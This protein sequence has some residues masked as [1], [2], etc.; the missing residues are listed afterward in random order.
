MTDSIAS[1][2]TAGVDVGDRYSVVCVLDASGD[3]VE[4]TRLATS[5]PAFK[6][7]FG[8][9]DRMRIAIEVGAHSPWMSDLLEGCGHEVLVANARE[10][11]RITKSDRKNDENDAELLARIARVDPRLL[12]P[13]RHRAPELRADLTTIRARDALVRS[14]T[15]L[16]NC[17][18]G[19]AK[20]A[21]V[22]LPKGSASAFHKRVVEHLPNEV[23]EA[24]EGLLSAMATLSEQIRAYD[25]KIEVLAETK[26]PESRLLQQIA[27]VGPLTALAF[28]LTLGDKGRFKSRDV[29]PYL[30]LVP[31]Q[32][33]S[34]SVDPQLRIS[35][36][37]NGL[38]RRLLVGSAHYVLGRFGPD[39]D[40]RRWGAS[41]A[42]RGGKKG[43]KRAAVAVAR[44]LSVL[45]HRLWTTAEVY[46]PLRIA[47][48]RENAAKKGTAGKGTKVN[49]AT[50][51]MNGAR[52]V[53]K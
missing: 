51:D 31:R 22:K 50:N 24:I 25:K 45:M 12:S 16:V 29:G 1:A 38:V 18:R 37:G 34:C 42:A 4:Q 11:E 33:R 39:T 14:R 20:S 3:V 9:R 48:K 47:T 27:G 49:D 26:Y 13:I 43:K 10:V 2:L 35:K 6:G 36:S 21:G 46:D 8:K 32:Q 7:A 23:G 52:K 5:K 40:L 30:G 44:K 53:T 41:I 28:M 15:K 19:I 17:V